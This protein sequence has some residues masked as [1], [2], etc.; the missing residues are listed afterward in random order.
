M[1]N[2]INFYFNP[3]LQVRRILSLEYRRNKDR[4][5]LIRENLVKSMQRH[6]RDFSSLEVGIALNTISIRQENSNNN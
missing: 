6:P 5:N 1:I 3:C 4:V 2:L